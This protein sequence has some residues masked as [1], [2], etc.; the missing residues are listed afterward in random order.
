MCTQLCIDKQLRERR[1]LKGLIDA[2][3]IET[4]NFVVFHYDCVSFSSSIVNVPYVTILSVSICISSLLVWISINT[5]KT[6][7]GA[8][9]MFLSNML[10]VRCFFFSS[11]KHYF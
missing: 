8:R 4:T 11:G 10:T 6:N 1:N 2:I 3:L 7:V 5:F 9:V